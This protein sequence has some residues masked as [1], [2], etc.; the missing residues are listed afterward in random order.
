VFILC[1]FYLVA[2][3]ISIRAVI[4]GK[5]PGWEAKDRIFHYITLS[6]ICIVIAIVPLHPSG[7]LIWK[8]ECDAQV[9]NRYIFILAWLTG[10]LMLAAT[11]W[12]VPLLAYSPLGAMIEY[13]FLQQTGRKTDNQNDIDNK[14][15]VEQ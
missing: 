2:I 11:I 5:F 3:I 13:I 6:I 14:K 1:I 9:A 8:C 12:I 7:Y 4:R 15:H 10:A